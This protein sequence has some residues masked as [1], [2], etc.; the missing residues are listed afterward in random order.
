MNI[1]LTGANG[2]LGSHLLR[3]LVSS[4]NITITLRST[5]NTQRIAEELKNYSIPTLIIDEA[6]DL[7]VDRFMC[8]HRIDT[9][10]HCATD[11]SRC[12]KRLYQTFQ[13]NVCFPMRLI[14]I[15]LNNS[16]RFLVNTDSYFNKTLTSYQSLVN[17]SYTKKTFLDYASQIGESLTVINM[18]LEHLYGEHDNSD[19]FIP[20]LV[21]RMLI[22]KDIC[23]THCHQK[24]D[25]V[26]V[27]DV[28]SAYSLVLHHL[29]CLYY[30]YLDLEVGTRKSM[31]LRAFI[32]N[33]QRII[34]SKSVLLFGL[35]DY[36]DDEIMNSCANCSLPVLGQKLNVSFN[37]RSVELGL[38]KM[39]SSYV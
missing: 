17:Y 11:Y 13:S 23:L 12:N 32:L 30:P 28:V 9:L 6:D 35:K 4:H 29:D 16:L 8:E 10:V 38:S 37:F 26:Y 5:S 20:F 3:K 27:D 19:K 24:R 1:L 39:L 31:T 25:F 22:D 34:G 15:G 33:L 2:F 21:D 36:R 18:R 7:L 14:E